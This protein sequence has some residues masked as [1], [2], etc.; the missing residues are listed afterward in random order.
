MKKKLL[1]LL[2]VLM[3]A[4]AVNAATDYGFS[5]AGITVTSDN[6]NNIVS[7]YI[8]SGTVYYTPSTNTLYMNNVTIT[9]TGDYN[10]VINN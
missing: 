6:C 4:L 7:N 10:R 1:L 3:T 2:A 9:M 8:T 5:V